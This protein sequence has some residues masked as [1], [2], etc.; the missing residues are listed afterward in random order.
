L[1]FKQYKSHRPVAYKDRSPRT[2]KRS[3]ISSHLKLHQV[4]EKV[5][6]SS[7][8]SVPLQDSITLGWVQPQALLNAAKS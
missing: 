1:Y 4:I 3:S 2:P 7:Q 8:S 6:Q 5:S